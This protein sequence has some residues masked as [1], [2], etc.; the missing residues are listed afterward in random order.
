MPE[1]TRE[2]AKGMARHTCPKSGLPMAFWVVGPCAGCRSEALYQAGKCPNCGHDEHGLRCSVDGCRCVDLRYTNGGGEI[3]P[4]DTTLA[5]APMPEITR[6]EVRAWLE[7]MARPTII[8]GGDVAPVVDTTHA[9]V[10]LR[11]AL[12]ALEDAERYAYMREAFAAG[13]E[14]LADRDT[15]W[16]ARFCVQAEVSNVRLNAFRG[17]RDEVFALEFDAAIDRARGT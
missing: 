16:R 6:E 2:E 17:T 3:A 7:S 4:I 10:C 14:R 15:V 1:T 12:A 9:A 13:A 5:E 8:V 11:L